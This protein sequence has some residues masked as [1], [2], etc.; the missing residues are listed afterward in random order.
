MNNLNSNQPPYPNPVYAW[1]VVTILFLAY[2]LSFVDRQIMSLLIEPIKQD[3]DIS[4]TQISILHGFAFAIFYTILGIPLGRL[5]DKKNRTLIISVGIFLW[6]F[7]TAACGLARTFWSLFVARIGVGVGEA[8]L[9]PAAY[10]MISDY[11]QKEKRGLAISLYSMGVFF[12]AGMAYLLGGLVVKLASQAETTVLPLI[13]QI[14]PWQ[15]TFFIVGVPGLVVVALMQTVKEPYRRDIMVVENSGRDGQNPVSIA[16]V[17]RFL[18]KHWRTYGSLLIGFSLLGTLTYG[19]FSWTPSF[20]IRTFGWQASEIGFAFGCIVITM[21]TF[22]ILLGGI[23]ADKE[24]ARGKLDACLRI[25]IV[26][27]AG[28][29]LFGVTATLMPN[30]TMALVMIGPTVVFLGLPVGLAPAALNQ[31]TPNQMRG[32]A[33]A[34]YIFTLNLIGLGLGPTVVAVITDYVFRDPLALRYS[35]ALFTTIVAIVAFFSLL[36]GL[37]PYRKSAGNMSIK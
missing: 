8:A 24:L 13:G 33:I 28:V 2:T 29:A 14:Q 3:L 20:F 12:G 26:A 4:D 6:S 15:L 37:R 34:L 5:A 9:S 27:A 31:I 36:F 22:G 30:A 35:L 7:M 17:A 11:F 18:L 16:D 1:Y 23:L 21:G 19:F 32:Q 10:S 25:S